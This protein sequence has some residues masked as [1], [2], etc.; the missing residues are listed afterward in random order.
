L[1]NL[2]F[3]TSFIDHQIVAK[4]RH[5]V[6]SPFVYQLLDKVIYDRK[7][8]A[9]YQEVEDLRRELLQDKRPV[10]VTDLGAGS[11][12]NSSRHKQVKQIAKD[13]LKS[14]SLAQLIH[15]I[16]N[17]FQPRN[18][19]ELGTSLGLT[20]AYLA[21]AVPSGHVTSIEGCPE[22]AAIAKENLKKLGLKNMKILTG[23]FD[24]V[25]PGVIEKEGS[26][27][28]LFIDGN[29]RREATLHYFDLCLPALN[30]NSIIIFD[31]I[32]WSRGMKE[33]WQQIKAHPRVTVTL[34]LFWIGI[35][36]FK[37][38]QAKEHFK[39]KFP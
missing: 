4:T 32:Y 24:A 18:I 37:K 20:T 17:E 8:R 12:L 23:H 33:A 36:F 25:L 10:A 39:I 14:P 3:I 31:D 13:A 7:P 1:I 19:V 16:A 30:E 5:G 35:V 29:H 28:L 11:M 15:R 21:G 2:Q 34:D 27:D 26:I 38:G 22:I 6:H 9:I